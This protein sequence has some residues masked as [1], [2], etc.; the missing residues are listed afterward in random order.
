MLRTPK[1][2]KHILLIGGSDPSGGA[3]I[4]ADLAVLRDFQQPA[5]SCITALTAQNERRVLQIHPTPTDLLT[6]QLAAAT[7]G[8]EIAAVKIGMVAERTN[9][10]AIVWFLRGRGYPNIV[11]DPVLESSSGTPLLEKNAMT[12]FR[13]DLLP[14][15]NVLTPNIPEA[16]QLVGS[17]IFDQATQEKA[18]KQIYEEIHSLRVEKDLAKPFVVIVKGGHRKEEAVDVL[19]DGKKFESFAALRIDNVN[20][21][22]TGCRFA[23]AIACGLSTGKDISQATKMAK[24]YLRKYLTS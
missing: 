7:E 5:L 9:V 8:K 13:K 2:M 19:Y 11:I 17:R 15:A 24:E 10:R 6:Q 1:N 12:L 16:M 22:G 21:R 3:G 4:Q 14:L 23:S 20:K 18:A